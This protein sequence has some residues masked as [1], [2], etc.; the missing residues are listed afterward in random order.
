[1]DKV[2]ANSRTAMNTRESYV[3]VCSTEKVSSN[4]VTALSTRANSRK[5][6]SLDM[7]STSGLTRV[8]TRAKCSMVLD[9]ELVSTPTRRRESSTMENGSKECAMAKEISST[10]TSQFILECG[11]V[12]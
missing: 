6:R 11:N 7:V 4:G 1:M 9:T 10:E 5:M 2:L 12:V 3:M 8:T